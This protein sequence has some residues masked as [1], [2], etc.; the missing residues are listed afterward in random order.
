M[1]RDGLRFELV[2][3]RPRQMLQFDPVS[4]IDVVQPVV[5]SPTA[6]EWSL[7]VQR[8]GYVQPEE[9][10]SMPRPVTEAATVSLQPADAPLGYAGRSGIRQ[11]ETQ[12]SEHFVPVEDR[13]R[14][15][16]PQ[17]DRYGKGHPRN[18]D[19]PYVQGRW[20]DPY[21]QNVL[22]GDYPIL[23]QNIFFEFTATTQA[24]L[25]PR[26]TPIGTTPF[27]STSRGNSQDFFGRP[28][29]LFYN[30][31]FFFSFDLFHGDAAFRPVDWRIKATPA[32]NVNYIA[33]NELAFVSPDVSKGTTRG[34]SF[35]TLQEWFVESKLADIGPNYDFASLR[36]GAQPFTSD[37]RGFIF[38]DVNRGVRL[39]GNN[40]S[41]RDQFNLVYFN[42]QEKDTN[43]LI[44]TFRDRQ[45]QV[46]IANY[47]RQDFIFP[48]YTT[49]LSVHYN[50][51]SPTLK[52][53][54][55]GFLVR[56][57]PVGV[58]QPHTIDVAYIGWAGDGHINRL[59]ISHAVY[60]AVGHDSL[61][62]LANQAQD[63]SA[64]MAA[65][66][67]SLD[68]DWARFRISGFLSSGDRN[69]NNGHATGFDSIMDNPNFAGGEFSYWQRQQLK[70]FGVNLV[71]RMSLIPDL[72]SSKFQGQTNFVNPGLNL[73]NVGADF[74]VT[75]KW[76]L[77]NN[78]NV[79]W[80]DSVQPLQQFTYQQHINHFI[81]VDLSI[82]TEYRPL[83]NNNVILKAGFSTLI[84]GQGFRD[85]FN[86]TDNDVRTL[87]AGFLEATLTF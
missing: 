75:P 20:W 69:L 37:F 10:P 59:N 45:Q 22:K 54:T 15:G 62:P 74:D 14:I 17:W 51:D 43:S 53:D 48:G 2:Q 57:D 78:A 35:V 47:Y 16:F 55:N 86:K 68:Y 58:F 5:Q 85:L 38:S 21:N 50:H 67:L 18:D 76:R 6:I 63:I 80:F 40:F 71:Q 56:P 28:G 49:Q 64:Y 30:Q 32:V 34:R 72:R 25:E 77:I 1:L 12:Q 7:P 4:T 33:V 26:Q 61:N 60:W 44:N 81:G 13:W 41:N 79:L 87:F 82:G 11:R 84:P 39:F 8:V 70:L 23:G 3:P 66:E 19:Y 36:L 83:L 29:Q 31:N 46:A 9:L 73:V 27:E 65:L 42:M 52:F 24:L